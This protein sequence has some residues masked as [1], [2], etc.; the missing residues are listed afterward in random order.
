MSLIGPE[1]TTNLVG[2]PRFIGI[3]VQKGGTTTLHNILCEHPHVLMPNHKEVHFFSRN[4]DCGVD[5]YLEQWSYG[6]SHRVRGEITPYYIFHPHA[7]QRIRALIPNIR[8]IILLRDPVERTLSHYFHSRR[9]GLEPLDLEAALV[10]EETR[11][12]GADAVLAEPGQRHLSHQEHSY[13]SR[14]RY[15]RQIPIWKRTFPSQQILLLKSEILF[16][17]PQQVWQLLQA[18]LGLPVAPFPAHAFGRING[19][20][21]EASAVPGKLKDWIRNELKPTYQYLAAV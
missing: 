11:L 12:D 4:Y 2:L 15:E 13:M 21:G 14:S 5:W 1:P 9:L 3:G 8:L 17:H 10:A 7:P 20:Q 18:F 16:H 6:S 19:G